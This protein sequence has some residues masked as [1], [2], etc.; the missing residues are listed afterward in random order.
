MPVDKKYREKINQKNTAGKSKILYTEIANSH[1]LFGWCVHR[2]FTY[3]DILHP[4]KCTV[5]KTV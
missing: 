2:T 5:V 4:L 1:V 3:G